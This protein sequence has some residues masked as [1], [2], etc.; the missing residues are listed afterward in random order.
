MVT[1]MTYLLTSLTLAI[2]MPLLTSGSGHEQI[3]DVS[4]Y[5]YTKG[6]RWFFLGA[7][8]VYGA[9]GMLVFSTMTPA[10][11]A[12]T[13]NVVAFDVF[14]SCI[15]ALILLAYVY[16]ARYR[17]MLD[18]RSLTTKSLF[19][20]RTLEL[21]RIAQIAVLRGRATDLMLFDENGRLLVKL[22]GSLQDFDEL[23]G[24]LKMH[25]QSPQV[26]L[27]KWGQ[28]DGWKQAVNS[29]EEHW[30]DSTG[31]KRFRDMNRHVN[32]L[33]IVGF[34]LIALAALVSYLLR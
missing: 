24:E 18:D 21:S 34:T 4:I 3:G 27:F 29:G 22:S 23:L 16:F 14:W 9:M 11:R 26:T 7:L 17:V 28:W 32:V 30:V 31:P 15:L 12:S 20:S 33:L 6:V 1:G 8:P 13:V 5:R 19:G 25:T 10:E 2:L